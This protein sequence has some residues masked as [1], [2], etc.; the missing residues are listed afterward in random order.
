MEVVARRIYDVIVS[1]PN[2]TEKEIAS[3]V[4]LKKTPYTRMIL[5]ALIEHGH[6]ARFWDESRARKAYVYFAQNTEKML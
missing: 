3:R 5:F 1:E 6:I 4:G 2:L